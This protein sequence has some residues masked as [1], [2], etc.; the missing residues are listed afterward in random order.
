MVQ[1]S[2]VKNVTVGPRSADVP[3]IVLD[4][5]WVNGSDGSN[6]DGRSYPSLWTA[7]NTS[8]SGPGRTP[9]DGRK[10]WTRQWLEFRSTDRH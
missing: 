2:R 10:V 9:A 7:R 6:G 5:A 8:I 3:R 1:S 4:R